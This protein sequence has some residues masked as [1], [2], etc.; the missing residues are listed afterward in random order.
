MSPTS[1]KSPS[2]SSPSN[3]RSRLSAHALAVNGLLRIRPP[4]FPLKPTALPPCRLMRSVISMLIFPARTISTISIVAS[5]VMRTPWRNFASMPSR[6]NILS[7]CGPPPWMMTGLIPTYFSKTTFCANRSLRDE[8]VIAW[9]PYLTTTV[10]P[11]NVRM[12]GRASIRTLAFLISLFMRNSRRSTGL[13]E[14]IPAQVLILDDVFQS[15]P[16]IGSRD[17][18]PFVGP[19]G[20]LERNVL[21]QPLHDGEETT[22]ADVLGPFIHLDRHFGDLLE[23]VFGELDGEAFRGQQGL[24]LPHQRSFR[25]RENADKIVF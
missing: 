4:S 12:Y 13:L 21:K 19:A 24:I 11:R 3:S 7:I 18:D 8:S 23:T 20:S 25:F 10:F 14:N 16:D 6:S 1:P 15:V 5:S 17:A 9:P 2:P 22:R